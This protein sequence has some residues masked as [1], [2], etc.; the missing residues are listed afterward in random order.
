M[1]ILD[2]TSAMICTIKG[3]KIDCK[4]SGKTAIDAT[5]PAIPSWV[6]FLIVITSLV[7][8]VVATVINHVIFSTSSLIYTFPFFGGIEIGRGT[9]YDISL[10]LFIAAPVLIILAFVFNAKKKPSIIVVEK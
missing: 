6:S 1:D 5:R 10:F 4:D 2:D 7:M 3:G 9:L 8:I